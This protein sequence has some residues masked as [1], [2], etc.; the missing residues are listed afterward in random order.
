MRA[1]LAILVGVAA[2]AP[3][4]VAP[5]TAPAGHEITLYRDRAVI[6]QRIEVAVPNAARS[7]VTVSVPAGVNVEDVVV[8]DRGQLTISE[9]RGSSLIATGSAAVDD[10]SQQ[11]ED[12]DFEDDPA[13]EREPTTPVPSQ[14][15][16]TP[17]E[18]TL[19]VAAPRAGTFPLHLGYVT[20]RM[21]WEAAYTM[22]TTAARDRVTLR[23]A[24]AIRNT[25]AIGFQ[26]ARVYVVDADLGPWRGRIAEQ[27]GSVI[28]GT[29][30]S[31]TPIAI[32]RALGRL[33]LGAGETR[34]ELLPEDPPRKMRSVLVYDPVGTKLDHGGAV[35]TADASLGLDAKTTAPHVTESF[36]VQRRV[37]SSE[38][39]PGGPVRLLERRADGNI[40]LLAE[41]RLFDAAT[42]VAEVDTIAIGTAAGVTGRRQRR[43]MTLDND[44]KRL[45]EEFV[46]TVAN[47]RTVPVE[48]VLREHLY[49]GQNWTLA[50]FTA[51]EAS[52]EGPQ[53]ISLRTTVP[54]RSE[55]KV[56]YV[57]VYTWP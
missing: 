32:P 5:T 40:S 49:R 18:L 17:T 52:K 12:E 6:K 30:S 16:V 42:R 31:T 27:L 28:A 1:A 36:E 41:S 14:E 25:S 54:A 37:A 13:P 43:E 4:I 48:V 11:R 57:V 55:S 47:T 10:P 38:G 2:C 7:V 53:Q 8:L 22:T 26:A 50:Y 45:V 19:V 29:V 15:S 20:D 33:D 46:L 3:R 34:V 35:P 9:L 23:G 24:I 44:G 51:R 56:F 39:L 21:A